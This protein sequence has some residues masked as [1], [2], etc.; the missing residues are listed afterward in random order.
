MPIAGSIGRALM[1]P[2]TFDDDGD[3][4]PTL[5]FPILPLILTD[6]GMNMVSG[7]CLHAIRAHFRARSNTQHAFDGPP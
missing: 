5:L 4:P 1:S 3:T 7:E 2:Q 6:E